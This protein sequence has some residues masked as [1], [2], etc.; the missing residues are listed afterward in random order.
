MKVGKGAGKTTAPVSVNITAEGDDGI[1]L[2]N[3]SGAVFT[4]EYSSDLF[5]ES[6]DSRF[7]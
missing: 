7:F 5:L 1:D 3:I 4:L 2:S 6:V